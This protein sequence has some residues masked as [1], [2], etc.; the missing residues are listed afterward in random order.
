MRPPSIS[1]KGLSLLVAGK[2]AA[3]DIVNLGMFSENMAIVFFG[4]DEKPIETMGFGAKEN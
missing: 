1:W 4:N 3:G 2:K